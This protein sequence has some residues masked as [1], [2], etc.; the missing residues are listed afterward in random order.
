MWKT[1]FSLA[2]MEN[3]EF[4]KPLT[5]K[6]LSDPDHPFVKTLI[7]I[8]SMESFIFSE[9]NKASRMKDESKIYFYGAFASAL[10]FIIHSGN[11]KNTNL[12][13][14]F[15]AYRGLTLHRDELNDKY[16][17]GKKINLQGFT[18]TTLLIEQGL[19]FCFS[20]L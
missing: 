11:F 9:L 8:Y 5:P 4:S 18:S 19:K 15:T 2:K 20:N 13:K 17:E 6:I 16:K 1:L 12:E 3:V 14:E 7:Y 10:G